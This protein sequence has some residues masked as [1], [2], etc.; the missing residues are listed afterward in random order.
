MQ[1][2]P[3]ATELLEAVQAHL[4]QDVV[5]S[6]G[7]PG[8]RFRTLVAANVLGIVNRE[9]ALGDAQVR[10][11]WQR[12]AALLGPDVVAP[13]GTVAQMDGVREMRKRLCAAITAGEYD[14]TER[15]QPLMAHCLR[16]AEEKLA[17]SN[18]QFL[19]RCRA[20]TVS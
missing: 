16:T 1:D 13:A 19:E 2:R 3:T 17:I 15:W 10:D 18:P 4:A 6:L 9:L 7:E 5:P 20:V 8:L 12:L 14:E 11:E